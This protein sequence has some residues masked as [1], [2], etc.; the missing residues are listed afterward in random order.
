VP[1]S[2]VRSGASLAL[3]V[4]TETLEAIAAGTAAHAVVCSGVADALETEAAAYVTQD[5]PHGRTTVHLWRAGHAGSAAFVTLHH[6][7]ASRPDAAPHDW[8]RGGHA[9]KTVTT[10]LRHDHV[11]ELPLATG[12]RRWSLLAVGLPNKPS[13]AQS[14]WVRSARRSLVAVDQVIGLA[15]DVAVGNLQ[16]TT[17]VPEPREPDALPMLSIRELQVL[18]LLRDGLLARS[19]AQRLDV[20]ERTVHKHLGNVYRKLDVHD[21][22][23]AVRRAESLGLLPRPSSVELVDLTTR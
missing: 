17:T 4:V 6:P 9:H 16:P 10:W 2:D 1:A 15:T 18:Q 5:A 12:P 8:W 19:I 21:R 11:V 3:R 22:L 13:P 20:S 7:A 23:V 14:Q